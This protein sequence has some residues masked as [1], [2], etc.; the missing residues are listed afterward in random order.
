MAL[1]IDKLELP[2]TPAQA[3][4]IIRSHTASMGVFLDLDRAYE[5]VGIL[6]RDN[7]LLAKELREISLDPALNPDDKQQV[8]ST[9]LA[10]GL[11]PSDLKLNGKDSISSK[12]LKPLLDEGDFEEEVDT[13]IKTYLKYS[14]NKTIAG[15]VN[16]FTQLPRC[17]VLS[18][19]GHRMVLARPRWSLLSTSRIQANDPNVQGIARTLGDLITYPKG[20][21]LIRADSGQIE[22]RINFSYFIRDEVIFRLI[23]HYNDAYFGLLNFCTMS[24]GELKACYEDFDANFV[25]IEITDAIKAKR[26]TL[27]TLSNAGSYGSHH[28]GNVD[29]SLA[30][31]FD[32]RIVKHPAR[33]AKEREVTQQVTMGITTFYGAFGTPITPDQTEKY[34]PGDDGWQDHII[35]CGI[36]NPVQTTASELMIC[37][38]N[39]ANK[40]LRSYKDSAICY[41]KHDEGAFLVSEKDAEK[42]PDLVPDLSD[43]TAYN[44]KGWI[45]IP[46]DPI[47]GMKEPT[48]RSYL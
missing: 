5:V 22:P 32:K 18:H 19:N 46:A 38:V 44:V 28:L 47:I 42:D 23:L 6:Q 41:Y 29:I 24:D 30:A 25:P 7:F 10:L 3:L 34:R 8:R 16:S 14:S 13:F 2:I 15:T 27:K 40:R 20:Y 45:P 37:S 11:R 39:A 43:I 12:V 21:I 31:S 36:N 1:T 26:Q 4:E 48:L 17:K 33:L 35:R 9:L